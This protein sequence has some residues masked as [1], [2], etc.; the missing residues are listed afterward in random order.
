MS[1]S[2][3]HGNNFE[4]DFEKAV[5]DLLENGTGNRQSQLDE[6]LVLY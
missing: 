2:D 1:K 4:D 3:E 5:D 6:K